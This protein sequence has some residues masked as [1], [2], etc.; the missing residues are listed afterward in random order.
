MFMNS[1][2]LHCAISMLGVAVFLFV[3]YG[4]MVAHHLAK[5]R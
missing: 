2:M 1:E 5:V 4:S 3:P